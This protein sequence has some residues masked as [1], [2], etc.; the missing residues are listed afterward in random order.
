MCIRDSIYATKV[1]VTYDGKLENYN[2]KD[3]DVDDRTGMWT[4]TGFL[5][6]EGDFITARHVIQPW[7]FYTSDQPWMEELSIADASGGSVKVTFEAMSTSG[8]SF[9]FDTKNAV[10]DESKDERINIGKKG[11]LF[12]KKKDLAIKRYTD[13]S[14]DWAYICLL[15]TSP[16]PRDRTR[17][18]MP[19]SA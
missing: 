19:S 11:G 16:S 6:K 18:R 3:W 9:T 1:E 2:V 5:T 4:G 15:Y 10:Y 7:R 8:T 12:R 17:S 14:T 13:I